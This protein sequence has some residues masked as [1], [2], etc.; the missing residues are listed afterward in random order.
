M[1]LPFESGTLWLNVMNWSLGALTAA[2][3]V[4]VIVAA[5]AVAM[6]SLRVSLIP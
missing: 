3:I 6:N 1:V 5:A 4:V 2:C